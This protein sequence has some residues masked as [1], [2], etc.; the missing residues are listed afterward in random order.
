ML[1]KNGTLNFPTVRLIFCK[2]VNGY[3]MEKSKKYTYN[4]VFNDRCF[5]VG[6]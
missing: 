1:S 2:G 4:Y 5:F 3:G 6:L